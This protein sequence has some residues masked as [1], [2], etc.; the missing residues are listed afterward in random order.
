[1]TPL[2]RKILGM[3][4]VLVLTMYGLLIF[5]VFSIESAAR[6][7]PRAGIAPEDW[8]L[9][10][11]DMQQTWIVIGSVIYFA[12]ALI[13]Y[14]WL[15]WLGIPMYAVGIALLLLLMAQGNETHR[16]DLGPIPFQPT[17]VAIASG[18]IMI[19]LCL[20][21]LPRLHRF[22][23]QPFV[24]LAIIGLLCGVPFLLVV[25]N[26]DMG[27]AIVWIPVAAVAIVVG[28]IPF[29]HQ[30]FLM[31][32]AIGIVPIIYYLALPMVS[33]RGTERIE[34]YL[35]TLE[36]GEVELTDETYAL[37]Y[38]TMAVGK[39]GWKGVGWNA[40]KAEQSIHAKKYIPW[41]TAHNDY[42]FAVI[43]EEHG[44]RGSLLLITA[45]T[46]LL[47]Q[48]LFISFYSCDFSGQLIAAGVVAL[49]FAHMFENI[50]MCIGLTPITGIPLP[51]VSYSGTFVVI[52][53]FLL[54]L[55]QSVWVHRKIERREEDTRDAEV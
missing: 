16:L 22:F 46:L 19:G 53:M 39:A 17:Q 38:V 40:T 37:Y 6:H 27:S 32:L 2:L 8:G 3:N 33:E 20:E 7:I 55:V 36:E 49:F 48:C 26:N 45:F 50:G 12:T 11:A 5:G 18:I 13:D 1:M 52:C 21:S 34:Q 23:A 4:W 9:A 54:G 28:G 44:F 43:A 42:I 25:K 41:K 47:I 24:K 14:R 10:F 51:L 30:L 35:E 15:K 29:R 31:L